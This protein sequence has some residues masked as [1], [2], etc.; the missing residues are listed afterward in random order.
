MWPDDVLTYQILRRN[1]QHKQNLPKKH[2]QDVSIQ[3]NNVQ[4][5]LLQVVRKMQLHMHSF[6]YMS[7]ELNELFVFQFRLEISQK[8]KELPAGEKEQYVGPDRYANE[9][10]FNEVP[11]ELHRMKP[12]ALQNA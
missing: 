11:L 3:S 4:V 10:G 12:G 7:Y 1:I 8:W 2:S 5:K 6:N 9:E